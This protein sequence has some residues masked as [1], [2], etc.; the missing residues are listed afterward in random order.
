MA[1]PFLNN[2]DLRNNEIQNVKIHNTGSS[3]NNAGGQV[4][5]NTSD[6]TLKYYSN[7]TDQW[8][9][10]SEYGV[11]SSTFINLT[12]TQT[13]SNDSKFTLQASLSA[14]GVPSSATYLRGDNIWSPISAIP[15]TYTW[16]INSNS[17]SGTV[18]EDDTISFIGGSNV[19]TSY[20][21]GILTINSS[22]ETI[23]LSGEVTGSGTTSIST[24]IAN[25]VLDVANFNANAIVTA[26]EGIESN[27]ND[28]TI[29]TSAAVKSYV[30]TAIVGGL[31]YQ[32]G[33]NAATNSPDLTTSPNTIKKGWTY[34]VTYDG[35]F[36]S[37]YVRVGDVLISEVDSPSSLADWTIVEKNNDLANISTVGLGNVNAATT[38][39]LKGIEVGYSAGTGTARVGLDI[40]GLAL[41]TFAEAPEDYYLPIYDDGGGINNKARLS[42]LMTF[43]NSVT[44]FST[45]ISASGT[46]THN[47]GT[48]DIIVQ[49]YDT[50]TYETV[51]ADVVRT[52]TTQATIT[53]ASTPTNSIKVLVQKIG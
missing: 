20:S 16:D 31:V 25:N 39:S 15:G 10:L 6:L 19:T 41:D 12:K 2:I 51:Y 47:L 49:L 1:V 37:E 40:V 43:A 50:A 35:T 48:R 52:N 11:S 53:F 45:T 46:I 13:N 17:G 23:T 24:T 27:D 26:A 30:D 34:T 8:I 38:D 3:P 28:T 5:F 14:A 9:T 21:A 29:P 36:I 22:N 18:N 33:Y 42:T 44:S 7:G 4:Y 32:G